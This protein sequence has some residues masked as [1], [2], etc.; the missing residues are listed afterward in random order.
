MATAN[1]E[2]VKRLAA[3]FQRAQLTSSSQ[4]LSE[5]NCIEVVNKLIQSNLLNVIFT[6]DGKECITPQYLVKEIRDE[7]YV[8]GGRVNLVVSAKNLKVDFSYISA[9]I[10]E[11]EKI[12]TGCSIILGQLINRTYQ[13]TIAEEINE[14]LQRTGQIAISDLTKVYDLP[15]DFLLTVVEK[16]LGKIIYANQD[17][18]D[19]RIFFTDAFVEKNKCILRGCLRALTQPIQVNVLA[20]FT[21]LQERDL[22]YAYDSL[23]DGKEVCGQ[24]TGRQGTSLLIPL[25]YTK[26]QTDW[27]DNFYKQNGYLEYDALTRL[28]ISDPVSFVQRHFGSGL[29]LELPTCI[30]GPQ[31]IS[32]VEASVQETIFSGSFL[33]ATMLLP[34]I[35]E[36]TDVGAVLEV[37]LKRNNVKTV[38][39]VFCDSVLI[40]DAYMEEL[41]KPFIAGDI[42][43][44]RAEE[45]VTSGAFIQAQYEKKR[46]TFREGRGFGQS[47]QKG[48]KKEESKFGKSGRW[49]SGSRDKNEGR[50]KEARCQQ[51]K[52]R[53]IGFGQRRGNNEKT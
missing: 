25:I 30:V 35:F 15:G 5:R 39:Q 45:S 3:D 29:M 34:S 32:Q 47:R 14:L 26:Q 46:E 4:T 10:P 50:Q 20:N 11:V 36:P 9:R 7:L 8:H 18:S 16:N 1:W 43:R 41:M 21:Q 22:F 51:R 52:R 48:R 53:S 27:V 19:S 44:T 49:Y 12:E 17:K 40:T 38:P 42:L 33:D 13:L 37:V 6:T 24:L 31:L 28:G 2:E 23:V